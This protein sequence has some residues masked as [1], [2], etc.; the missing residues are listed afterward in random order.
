LSS[1][2]TQLATF[3]GHLDRHPHA[4]LLADAAGRVLY[5]NKAAR[6]IAEAKDGIAI[7]AG[8][9]SVGSEKQAAVF[10]E[11]LGSIASCRDPSMR[12]MEVPRPSRKQ[13]YRVMLMPVQAS[14]WSPLGVSL[15]AVTVLI[16]DSDSQ[17]GP[18]V[19]ALRELFALTPAEARV[20]GQLAL[21]RSVEEIAA[22]ASISVETVRTHLKRTLSKTG[23]E[24]QGE[25]ISL[26]LRSMS[27][28][29]M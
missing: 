19:A 15:P 28:L 8:G 20:T 13:P 10:R 24:R 26:I 16:V 11:A 9:I 27:F 4:L 29:R 7:E 22:E 5:A 2:R 12:R 23:T 25:L 21:G 3:T 14:G 17:P 18:D 6:E 1:Q